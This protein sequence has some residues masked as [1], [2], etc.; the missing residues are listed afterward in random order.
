MGELLL[1]SLEIKNF[2]AFKHLTIERLGRVNLI[3][4][5]N[6]VG[7]TSLLEALWLYAYRGSPAIIWQILDARDEIKRSL[8][9]RGFNSREDNIEN[10]GSSI[11]YLFYGSK[12]IEVKQISEHIQIGSAISQEGT[13]SITIDWAAE[14]LDN[15]GKRQLVPLKPEE[16]LNVSDYMLGLAIWIGQGQLPVFYPLDQNIQQLSQLEKNAQRVLKIIRPI[17]CQIV[18]ATGL[19]KIQTSRLWDN[20]VLTNLEDSITKGLNL[21]LSDVERVNFVG[22]QE[23]NTGRF[24]VV[25]MKGTNEAVP[26]SRLGDGVNRLFSLMLALVNAKD[27][28]LLVDEIDTGLHYSIQQDVWCLIFDLARRLNV[29]VFATTHSWDCIQTFQKAAQEDQQKEGL[30]IRLQDKKGQIEAAFLDE[31]ELEIATRKQIEVR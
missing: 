24:P 27:G 23:T 5:K 31:E 9:A 13:L 2:R 22:N 10:I 7:K 29:Q 8:I 20:I 30:L 16:Y 17:N 6:N 25:K 19:N 12:E 15:D 3:V 1:D 4:G 18:S 28:L 14:R 26:L 21:I 11:R